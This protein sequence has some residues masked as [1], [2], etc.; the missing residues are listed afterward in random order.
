MVCFTIVE[1][2][3]IL[4]PT[5]YY[6]CS[7]FF[8]NFGSV[9]ISITTNVIFRLDRFS[10]YIP[11]GVVY[12][13]ALIDGAVGFCSLE[14]LCLGITLII[15]SF[16]EMWLGRWIEVLPGVIHSQC[17]RDSEISDG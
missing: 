8:F 4:G 15:F 2:S 14:V 3:Q 10:V 6:T 1:V 17:P 7:R 16:V 13:E 11:C 9:S 5:Y 12:R